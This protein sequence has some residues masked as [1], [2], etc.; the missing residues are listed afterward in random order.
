MVF[1]FEFCFS[2]WRKKEKE[3]C[4]QQVDQAKVP[5]TREEDLLLPPHNQD[6]SPE[7]SLKPP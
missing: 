2:I 3:T 4:H 5:G 1:E 6:T 7:S